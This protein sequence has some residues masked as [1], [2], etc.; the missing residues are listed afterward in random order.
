LLGI[1]LPKLSCYFRAGKVFDG[2]A[3]VDC[4]TLDA[5]D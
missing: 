2:L 4:R 3:F 5:F 1:E